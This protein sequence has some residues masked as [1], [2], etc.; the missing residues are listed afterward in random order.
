[1]NVITIQYVYI[2]ISIACIIKYK[3]FKESKEKK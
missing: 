3:H 2:Y 1:M